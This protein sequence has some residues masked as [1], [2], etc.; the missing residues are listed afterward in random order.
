MASKGTNLDW[1]WFGLLLSGDMAL[2]RLRGVTC[3]LSRL[4]AAVASPGGQ[5]L[6]A[7]STAMIRVVSLICVQREPVMCR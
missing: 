1:E 4:G 6:P 3:H 2:R 5:Q 7:Q